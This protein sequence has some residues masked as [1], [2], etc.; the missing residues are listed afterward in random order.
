MSL[1]EEFIAR[2]TAEETSFSTICLDFGISRTLGYKILKKFKSEGVKGLEPCSRAP[3]FSPNKTSDEVEDKILR[4]RLQHPTW[5]ARKIRSYLMKRDVKELPSPST[6]CEIL[7]RNGCI[8]EEDSLK[9]QALTRFER[10]NP[11]ELWQMDFKGHFQLSIKKTCY[12]LTIIDDHS[13]FSLCLHACENEGI[14]TVKNQLISKFEQYGMPLQIN[15]DNGKPWGNSSLVK[16]TKLTVWL[17]QLDIRVT[18]SRPRHPQTNGKNERFHRTLKEDVLRRQKLNNFSDAQRIFDQWRHIYN[19]ERP[20]QAIG[21]LVPADRY[22]PSSRCMPDKLPSIEYNESAI[23]RKTNETG[24]ISYRNR[25]YLAGKAFAGY[26]IEIKPNDL[27]GVIELYFGKHRI[28]TYE[29]E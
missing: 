19:Y 28:Y 4:V 13:R 23:V 21:M 16:Y 14:F 24:Y 22:Q 6:I 10:V 3:H 9:R 1:K 2:I 8:S 27:H 26:Y 15:V 11:N 7:K 20:H 18:H 25:N 5:G 17:M 29:L 12:P